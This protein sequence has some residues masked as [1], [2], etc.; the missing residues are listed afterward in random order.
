M[1]D[2]ANGGHNESRAN[3]VRAL[4]CILRLAARDT[5]IEPPVER[6]PTVWCTRKNRI[7]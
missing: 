1:S 6:R 3:N 7:V 2:I 4:V 5:Q